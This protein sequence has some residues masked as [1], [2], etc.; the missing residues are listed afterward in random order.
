MIG[1][2]RDI[3]SLFRDTDRSFMEYLFDLWSYDDVRQWA[4][5]IYDRLADG[6]MPCDASWDAQHVQIFRDWINE[7]C[8]P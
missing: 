5:P 1:F 2:E 4:E 3:K 6:T 8:A 7:G